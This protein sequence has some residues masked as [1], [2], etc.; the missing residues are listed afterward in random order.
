VLRG[1]LQAG[2]ITSHQGQPYFV[3]DQADTGAYN[4]CLVRPVM[5]VID[6]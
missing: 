1:K 3:Q 6:K 5:F 4:A 2:L